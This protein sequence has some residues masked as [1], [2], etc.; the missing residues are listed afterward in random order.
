MKIYTRYNVID[1]LFTDMSVVLD[2][3]NIPSGLF[4]GLFLGLFLGPVLVFTKNQIFT[5]VGGLKVLIYKNQKIESCFFQ[6]SI[7]RCFFMYF[8]TNF[9]ILNHD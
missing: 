4:F 7:H 1:D 8:S 2:G 3:H 9:I 6:N 5:S